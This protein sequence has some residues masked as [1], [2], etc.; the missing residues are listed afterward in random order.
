MMNKYVVIVIGII[1]VIISALT[2]LN[3]PS[4]TT[5]LLPSPYAEDR[6]SAVKVISDNLEFPTGVAILPDKR[7]VITEQTGKALI[8][9][10]NGSQLN[11]Y[12]VKGNYFD[13]GA[14]LLGLAIHPQYVNNHY[15]YLYYTYKNN[16]NQTF[17]KVIRLQEKNN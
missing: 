13:E 1:V 6:A 12:E 10:N 14:G 16:D 11:N 7:I 2:I 3:T 17:N 4:E 9:N 15:L 8:L 5:I